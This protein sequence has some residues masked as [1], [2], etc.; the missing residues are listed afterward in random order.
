MHPWWGTARRR[1]LP[2]AISGSPPIRSASMSQ[3]FN[4][5]LCA[6]RH[7][8]HRRPE[9]GFQ[10]QGTAAFVSAQL[11]ALGLTVHGGIGGTGLVASL[12]CGDDPG[13]IGLR[14]DMDA[15]AMTETGTPAHASEHPGCMHGCG[16]DGHMAMVLGAAALLT[17]RRDFNGTVRFVFQPAEEHGRGAKAMM[18]DG[19][20]E[21][22]PVDAIFGLHNMPGL[23]LGHFAGRAGG[24]MAAEDNFE[25]RI[26]G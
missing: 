10:E 3:T 18:A 22:F 19:L 9:L 4:A 17:E 6:W 23:P 11:E 14:A 25:I 13:V 5:Q 16:H 8:L 1:S 21:R 24:I 15:L 20:F 26:T 12:R 7:A 2:V